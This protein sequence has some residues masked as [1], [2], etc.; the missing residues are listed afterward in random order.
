VQVH[1]GYGYT[2][3]Y[4]PEAWLRDQKLNTLHEGTSGIQGLDLLGRKAV[5]QG[6]AAVPQ[7]ECESLRAAMGAVGESHDAPRGLGLAGD[8]EGMLL[9]SA[10]YLQLF[11]I[12]LIAWQW[13]GQAAA[14]REGLAHG[15]A[16]REHYEGVL[17]A[18]QIRLRTELP[19]VA[20]LA[21]LCKSGEDS[22]ARVGGDWL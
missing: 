12:V 17:C 2:S 22:Y 7:E 11:S 4:L 15:G 9:H 21:A 19:R 10:D 5:A 1:G 18:A 6:G 16:G 20:Q 8:R 13:L 3:E 14:A